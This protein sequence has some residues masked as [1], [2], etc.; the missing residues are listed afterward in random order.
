MSMQA[1]PGP[2]ALYEMMLE[3]EGQSIVLQARRDH[4]TVMRGGEREREASISAEAMEELVQSLRLWLG[5]RLLRHY[6]RTGRG[7]HNVEVEVTVNTAAGPLEPGSEPPIR[8]QLQVI[9]GRVRIGAL[10]G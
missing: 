2:E 6:Q 3:T 4:E 10:E 1:I 8:V 7:A 5:T 9:N